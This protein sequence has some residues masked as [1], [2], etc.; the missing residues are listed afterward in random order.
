MAINCRS[1][2][3]HS[4]YIRVLMLQETCDVRMMI[5]PATKFNN[6]STFMNEVKAKMGRHL[7][8][9]LVP[10]TRGYPWNYAQSC[11]ENKRAASCLAIEVS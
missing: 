11:T 2:L 1:P 4:S 8:S 9:L 5:I 7:F 6:R 10:L 3:V